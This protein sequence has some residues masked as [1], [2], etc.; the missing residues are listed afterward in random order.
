MSGGFDV[1]GQGAFTLNG[2]DGTV[3]SITSGSNVSMTV[4]FDTHS[5]TSGTYTGSILFNPTSVNTS[6][7][8]SLSQES[9]GV[10]FEVVPEPAT[11][12]MIVGGLGMMAFVQRARRRM[13][14]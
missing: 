11:W 10:E 2:F 3:S 1:S 6:G 12:S 4:S 5:M 14:R 13:S 9:L 7:T 8:S